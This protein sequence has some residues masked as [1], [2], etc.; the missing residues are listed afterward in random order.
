MWEIGK[1][2][3][4]LGDSAGRTKSCRIFG[5][6][7]QTF[8]PSLEAVLERTH[9]EDR[10][11]LGKAY[12]DAVAALSLEKRQEVLSIDHRIVLDDGRIKIVQNTAVRVIKTIK[13]TRFAVSAQHRTLP[14]AKSLKMHYGRAKTVPDG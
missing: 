7:P 2:I 1:L 12:A 6:D 4:L 3:Y 9:P 11:T 5:V 8:V 14:S 10:A 13:A